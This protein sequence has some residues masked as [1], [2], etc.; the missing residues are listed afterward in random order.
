MPKAQKQKLLRI[1]IFTCILMVFVGIS[2]SALQMQPG[3]LFSPLNSSQSVQSQ[4]SGLGDISWFLAVTR[5]FQIILLLL[6]PIYLI[7]SLL[8][9]R[10]RRKLGLDFLRIMILFL[11]LMWLSEVGQHFS[12]ADGTE[13]PQRG[14]LDFS[15]I[16]QNAAEAPVFAANPQPWMLTLIIFGVAALAAAIAYYG[17]KSRSLNKHSGYDPLRELAHRAQTALDE[18]E[19]AK[20]EFD[21]VII[22]CYAEMSQTLQAEKGI[23]RAEAMT[24]HEFERVLLAKGFPGQPVQQLTQL[25]EQVRYGRRKL[26]DHAK[27]TA[28]DSLREIIAFCRGQ[29]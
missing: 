2:L 6:L 8:S 10:G 17:L 5:G 22:R 28:T 18:I 4:N 14:F 16:L 19:T 11:M 9:K 13:G 29:A 12:Q 25:F 24:P 26:G 27:Q 3:K 15:G 1:L 21:D 7:V 20:I 23:R